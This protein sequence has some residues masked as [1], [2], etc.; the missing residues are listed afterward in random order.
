MNLRYEKESK[1]DAKEVKEG[2]EEK[3]VEKKSGFL[4]KVV[5]AAGLMLDTAGCGDKIYNYNYYC[6]D[7]GTQDTATE[8]QEE[9]TQE[10]PNAEEQNAEEQ[11]VDMGDDV[12]DEIEEVAEIIEDVVEEECIPNLAPQTCNSSEPI[13]EGVITLSEPL[14]AG[15]ITFELYDTEEHSGI[16]SALINVVDECGNLLE[17]NKAFEGSTQWIP[18][19]G[20]TY[21]VTANAVYV[22]DTNPWADISIS[23]SCDHMCEVAS[24][25]LNIGETLPFDV[26]RLHL[27]DL[28]VTVPGEIAAAVSIENMDGTVIYNRYR[29]PKGEHVYFNAY[30]IR[31]DELTAGYTL[32]AKWG[33]F[34]IS[35]RCED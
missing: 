20:A 28:D 15:N 19:E 8:V 11:N 9:P 2:P 7:V 17:R 30:R 12:L 4:G 6:S 31:A 23:I 18:I 16:P 22:S 35:T 27:D 33:Q 10:E 1:R 32:S 26:Y 3:G 14:V 25:I 29:I 21:I 34:T 24:G 5:L 13:A